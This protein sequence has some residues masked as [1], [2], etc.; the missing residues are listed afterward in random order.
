MWK[1]RISN[2]WT[3]NDLGSC[4][5]CREKVVSVNKSRVIDNLI[6]GIIPK[7]SGA[8]KEKRKAVVAEKEQMR[9]QRKS[10]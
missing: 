5:V 1:W 10:E 4:P 2:K 3:R 9:E 6:E 7:M 8:E